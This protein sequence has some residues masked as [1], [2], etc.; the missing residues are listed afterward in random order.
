M[1]TITTAKD[2]SSSPPPANDI[3]SSSAY[4]RVSR[5]KPP[6]FKGVNGAAKGGIL[7]V[8]VTDGLPAGIYKLTT[9][10]SAANHQPVLMP[11]AQHR[12]TE[13]SVFVRSRASI[14]YILMLILSC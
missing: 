14:I 11:V 10:N 6:F 2:M 5:L 8:D 7:S 1:E 4:T 3:P 12:S 13:D 9:I